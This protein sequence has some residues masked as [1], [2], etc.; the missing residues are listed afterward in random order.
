MKSEMEIE[1][2]DCEGKIR[3]Q[4]TFRNVLS[5]TYLVLVS[6]GRN[7]QFKAR[8]SLMRKV[9]RQKRTKE[10]EY[11]TKTELKTDGNDRIDWK[12]CS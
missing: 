9:K 3:T 1:G 12:A 4:A 10:Y 11:S 2:N 6:G 8:D 7:S 5:F